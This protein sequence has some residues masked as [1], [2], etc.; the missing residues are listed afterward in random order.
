MKIDPQGLLRAA[1]RARQQACARHSGFRVG[2]ALRTASGEIFTGANVES[3][4]YGLSCCAE[5]VALFKGLTNGEKRFVA[6]A[7]VAR[8][9]AG[10]M[11]CGACRQLLAD[12]APNATVFV[13]DSRALRTHR[14]FTVSE[15]LPGA[16]TLR[17]TSS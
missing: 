12:Y 16:F 7:V 17:G 1:Y 5:R 9:K 6:I 11:P 13:A 15:L 14:S 4:S 2:A 3:D 10:P 8:I